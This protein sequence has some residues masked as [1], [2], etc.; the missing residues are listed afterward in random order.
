MKLYFIRDKDTGEY[1]GKYNRT[2]YFRPGVLGIQ[3]L[4]SSEPRFYSSIRGAGGIRKV[5]TQTSDLMGFSKSLRNPPKA[6]VKNWMYG[7][8]KNWEVIEI[9]LVKYQIVARV[10][11]DTDLGITTYQV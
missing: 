6:G 2:R 1:W 4:H 3:S 8:F 9:T 11:N 5:L 7:I 10:L